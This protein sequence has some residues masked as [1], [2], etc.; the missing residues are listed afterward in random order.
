MSPLVRLGAFWFV[1]MGAVGIFFPFFSLYLG[2]SAG[3]S[4]F[5]VGAVVSALPVVGMVAQPLWG[6]LADRSGARGRVLALVAAG[7]GLAQ[8]AVAGAQGFA[9]LL[10]ATALLAVFWTS[11]IPMAMSVSLAI[12][13]DAGRHAFGIARACG[14]V[15]YLVLVVSFPPVLRG[16]FGG[17]ANGAAPPGLAWMFPAIAVLALAGAA[18]ALTL[19]REGAVSLRAPRDGLRQLL[20]HPPMLRLLAYCFA[21]HLF[22]NGPIQLFPLFVRS[23]GG[24]IED[25]SRMWI[26]MVLLEIPLM[27]LSG[28][29]LARLGS[30]RLLGLG[31]VAAGVRWA[32]SGL[33]AGLA[34]TSALGLLHGLVVVGLGIG[35]TL[36]VEESVPEPLR[37]TG[38]ALL[39]T[40]GV[41]AGGIVSNLACG[42]LFDHVGA[43]ATYLGCGAGALALGLVVS[44]ALPHARRAASL[45]A[46]G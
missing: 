34:I 45:Q 6:Q 1:Y 5:E 24:G 3:L 13:R 42:W 7:A 27:A 8:L 16:A 2:E 36:Y 30:R 29:L 37:S 20:R 25:V 4:G 19:P 17:G 33:V 38:Q 10:A 11:A 26:W 21:V 9:A 15:G 28:T 22:I 23:L 12:L 32:G 14:T 41:G 35:A 43:R 46:A 40:V 18:I 44:W 31:V 39:A